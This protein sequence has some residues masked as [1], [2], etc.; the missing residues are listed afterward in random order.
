MALMDEA[1]YA[2]EAATEQD[3]WWFRGRRELFAAEIDRL[4]LR[5]DARILDVGTSTGTNL[6]MLSNLGYTNVVGVDLSPEAVRYCRAKGLG[7][8]RLA[9]ITALPFDG[10]T[11]DLVLATDV[12]EHVDDDARAC[13]ELARV[14]SPAGHVLVTVPA[15]PS[16]WGLQDDRAHHKRRYR[17]RDV[18]SVVEGTGLTATR[19][20][21]FNYLLFAAIWLARQAIRVA[22]PNLKSEGELNSPMLN[23]LL[24][25]VFRCDVRS[26]PVLKPPFGVSA[27][28]LARA[29][30]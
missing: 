16:L 17:L 7:D 28:V 6:R 5:R 18:V 24:L 21:Y 10:G 22:R 4:G 8:V 13:R 3:H 23:R 14:I 29:P 12:I 15:F 26:A 25:G 9:D 20:Y 19:A 27:F 30:P 1:V 11:F 2:V